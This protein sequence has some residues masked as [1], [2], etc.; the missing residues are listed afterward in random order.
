M[1]I[2]MSAIIVSASTHSSPY[3]DHLSDMLNGELKDIEPRS[4][5]FMASISSGFRVYNMFYVLIATTGLG[6][7]TSIRI[8]DL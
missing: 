4:I 7:G 3:A 8:P 5:D 6:P 1:P 2:S